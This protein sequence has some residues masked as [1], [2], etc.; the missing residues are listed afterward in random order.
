M[1]V[2]REH[3]T[4]QQSVMQHVDSDYIASA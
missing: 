3:S 1:L 4:S 2:K